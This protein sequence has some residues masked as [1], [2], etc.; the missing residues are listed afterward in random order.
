MLNFG[1]A[2]DARLEVARDRECA[3]AAYVLTGSAVQNWPHV[4]RNTLDRMPLTNVGAYPGLSM[5]VNL[6]QSHHRNKSDAP[7]G[8][9]SLLI[10]AILLPAWGPQSKRRYHYRHVD[11]MN[12]APTS[13]VSPE[14]QETE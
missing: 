2:I 9:L 3:F 10:H 12:R 4:N 6:G 8:G 13:A 1:P 11:D 5:S 14:G 7:I